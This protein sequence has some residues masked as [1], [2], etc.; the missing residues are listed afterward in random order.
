MKI[1]LIIVSITIIAVQAVPVPFKLAED[2][3]TKADPRKIDQSEGH[4]YKR[5]VLDLIAEEGDA[6]NVAKLTEL[7]KIDQSEAFFGKEDK[8]SRNK[9]TPDDFDLDQA[10]ADPRVNSKDYQDSRRKRSP[11]AP[12]VELTSELLKHTSGSDNFDLGEEEGDARVNSKDYQDSRKKRSPVAPL[13]ELTSELLKHTS[14]SD[15]FDLVEEEGYAWVNSKDYQDSR[16]K[17]SPV[18]PLVELT[19]KLLAKRIGRKI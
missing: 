17:R 13:V 2:V 19:S 7:N 9:R 4:R 5:S 6:H 8:T 14:G 12:L 15:N 18:A 11:V 10:E 16:K 1:T 3:I